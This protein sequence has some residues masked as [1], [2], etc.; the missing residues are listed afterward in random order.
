MHHRWYELPR[1]NGRAVIDAETGREVWVGRFE[2]AERASLSGSPAV[3]DTASDPDL[4][5]PF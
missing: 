4:D 2:D 1:L 5:I 3:P